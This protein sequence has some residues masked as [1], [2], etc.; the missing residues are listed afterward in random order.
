MSQQTIH[1]KSSAISTHSST[2]GSTPV[3]PHRLISLITAL[4]SLL[5]YLLSGV[6]WTARGVAVQQQRYRQSAANPP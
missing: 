6:V 1:G 3:A 4:V 2:K 5:C